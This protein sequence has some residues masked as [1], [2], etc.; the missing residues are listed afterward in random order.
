[1]RIAG[2]HDAP[3]AASSAW[4]ARTVGFLTA[5]GSFRPGGFDG[6]R[7][8][9][10]LGW[11]HRRRRSMVDVGTPMPAYPLPQHVEQGAAAIEPTSRRSFL[12]VRRRCGS[13]LRNCA[14]SAAVRVMALSTAWNGAA[15]GGAGRKFMRTCNS[16]IRLDL[17]GRPSRESHGFRCP[18]GQRRQ[19]VHDAHPSPACAVDGQKD[20]RLTAVAVTAMAANGDLYLHMV[21]KPSSPKTR[22]T[23]RGNVTSSKVLPITVSCRTARK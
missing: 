17:P 6:G 11:S 12:D 2:L 1:M 23:L 20:C 19:E 3:T 10:R 14:G 5:G 8:D 18:P 4:A 15:A 13:G 16:K 9:I 22:I 21:E 7:S